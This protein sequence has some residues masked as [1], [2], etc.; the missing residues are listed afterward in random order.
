MSVELSIII[1]THNR[2][3][4]L[5]ECLDSFVR[6]TA[7]ASCF[8]VII[9]DNASTDHTAEVATE[10]E[11]AY[12]HFRMVTE[13]KVGLS[14][15]RNLGFQEAKD[16]WISYVDDDAKAAPNYVKRALET[17]SKHPFDCFGGVFLPWYKY[18][19]PKWLPPDFGSNYTMIADRKVK[20]LVKVNACGGVIVF[21]KEALERVGGFAGHLGMNGTQV[22]YG[23]ED[24][25]QEKMRSLGYQIG[26]DPELQIH[27]LVAKYKLDWRWHIRSAYAHGAAEA[28]VYQIRIRY[29]RIFLLIGTLL[30]PLLKVP[31]LLGRVLVQQRYYWQNAL[32]DSLGPAAHYKGRYDSFQAQRKMERKREQEVQLS[33]GEKT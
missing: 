13:E 21:R 10:F 18:G 11:T 12:P 25:V 9:V 1:C 17:I 15:A 31:Y 24:L 8:E 6:Q 28:E 19:K 32:I 22:A 29:P 4:I 33:L 3:D 5:R 30:L 2:A 26:L 27:H 20:P 23:E 16:E 7:E 14:Y